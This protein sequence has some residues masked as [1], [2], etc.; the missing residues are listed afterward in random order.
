LNSIQEATGSFIFYAGVKFIFFT[1]VIAALSKNV[2]I[3]FFIFTFSISPL[4]SQSLTNTFPS[5]PAFLASSG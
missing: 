3:T 1:A 5:L 4:T 2:I